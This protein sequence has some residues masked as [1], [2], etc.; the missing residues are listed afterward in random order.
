MSFLENFQDID[1]RHR[2]RQDIDNTECKFLVILSLNLKR[3]LSSVVTLL[4]FVSK[5]TS[6]SY[7]NLYP[8]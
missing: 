6:H 4:H 3:D 2:H 5:L 8:V 1:Y 7:N